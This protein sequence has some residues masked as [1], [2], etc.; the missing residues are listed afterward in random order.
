M[1]GG[2]NSFPH[3]R[4]IATPESQVFLSEPVK[5]IPCDLLPTPA[6]ARRGVVR[7][8]PSPRDSTRRQMPPNRDG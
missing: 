5:V 4:R 1:A 6:E 3:P 7:I 2:V 8:V